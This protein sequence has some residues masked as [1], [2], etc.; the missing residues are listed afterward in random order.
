MSNFMGSVQIMMDTI[1]HLSEAHLK[2]R[3][4]D[5]YSTFWRTPSRSRNSGLSAANNSWIRCRT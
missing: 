4:P 3:S 5:V 2:M 1:F